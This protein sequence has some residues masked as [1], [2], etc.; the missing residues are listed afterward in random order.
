MRSPRAHRVVLAAAAAAACFVPAPAAFAAGS[1]CPKADELPGRMTVAEVRIATLCLIN[2]ERRERGLKPLRQNGRLAVAGKRHVR[3]MVGARYFAHD[4]RAGR[5]FSTRIMRTGYTHNRRAL[6]GE[7]LAWGTG[8]FASP[9]SIVRG[10]MDSPGHRANILQ[11]NFRE[12][13]IAVVSGTP[14][15]G[16]DGATYAT[17]FGRL[18]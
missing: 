15:S 3:D 10:W 2:A 9:R 5:R 16:R 14:Q 6:L 7:N 11:P 8:S 4:S 17:E 12:I 13:G 18:F 1:T